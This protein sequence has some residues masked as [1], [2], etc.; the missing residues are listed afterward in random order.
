MIELIP[1]ILV[2]FIGIISVLLFFKI[3]Q[4]KKSEI[5]EKVVSDAITVTDLEDDNIIIDNDLQESKNPFVDIKNAKIFDVNDDSVMIELTELREPL[6]NYV[7]TFNINKQPVKFSNKFPVFLTWQSVSVPNN[8]TKINIRV[9]KLGD[10]NNWDVKHITSYERKREN[11]NYF[12]DGREHLFQYDIERL[13]SDSPG[14]YNITINYFDFSGEE[15]A[16][17]GN[18]SF[19]FVLTDAQ[20]GIEGVKHFELSDTDSISTPYHRVQLD[21]PKFKWYVTSVYSDMDNQTDPLDY[22]VYIMRSG[23]SQGDFVISGYT[24]TGSRQL[25][26]LRIRR[27]TIPENEITE[28]EINVTKERLISYGKNYSD[29]D[30]ISYIQLH[31]HNYLI[32][33]FTN[34]PY[35]LK[36]GGGWTETKSIDTHI[37]FVGSDAI[38]NLGQ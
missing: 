24:D 37:K 14:N 31:Y 12:L 23:Y 11:F 36:Y 19:M 17:P 2:M 26:G 10:N 21:S 33:Q 18:S 4:T 7:S 13:N 16:F 25:E 8:V 29:A 34:P 22:P 32:P 38:H 28:D 9:S 15:Y 30:C 6:R 3:D 35:Y 27:E 1:I 20:L 5:T